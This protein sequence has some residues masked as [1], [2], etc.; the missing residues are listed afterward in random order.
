MPNEEA[1]LEQLRAMLAR[2]NDRLD[3]ASSGVGFDG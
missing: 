3:P 2:V 1:E